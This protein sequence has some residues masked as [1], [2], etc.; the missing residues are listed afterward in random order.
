MKESKVP[1]VEKSVYYGG[2]WYDA[3]ESRRSSITSAIG[4]TP[5][6]PYL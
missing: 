2:D 1:N 6:I 3:R 5:A 4:R